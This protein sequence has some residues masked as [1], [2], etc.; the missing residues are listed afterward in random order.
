MYLLIVYLSCFQR[1]RRKARREH[2][3]AKVKLQFESKQQVTAVRE[4]AATALPKAAH[5]APPVIEQSECDSSVV[6]TEEVGKLY[7]SVL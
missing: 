7:T 4:S 5:R 6:D 1:K 3:K 2:A